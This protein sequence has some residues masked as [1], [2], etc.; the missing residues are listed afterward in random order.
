MERYAVIGLGR[1]GSRLAKLL[2]DAGAEVVAIDRR[3]NLV[4][5]MRDVVTR[6]VRLDCTDEDALRSQGIDEVDV[7]VVGI[8][9]AFEDALLATVLLKK[10]LEVPRVISRATSTIRAK[11]LAQ[12]GA[13]EVVNPERESA[14][15]WRTRLIAPRVMERI[16][17][18]DDFSFVQVQPPESFIDKS[19]GELDVRKNFQVQ[20]VAIRR[21]TQDVDADGKTRTRQLLISV[22]MAETIIKKGDVL[23]MIGSNDALHQFGT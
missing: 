3:E 1:F 21:T 16:E 22:P 11:I 18:A 5:D 12:I 2:A 15:R 20:V 17:L 13:D 8:G 23:L 6:A 10:N 19:L 4:E 14:E 9:T 7:A